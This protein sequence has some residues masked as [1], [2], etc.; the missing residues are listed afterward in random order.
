LV[1]D[2]EIGGFNDQIIPINDQMTRCPNDQMR[3]ID[4]GEGPALVLIPGIQGRWEYV[5]PAVEALASSF[6]VITFALCDE[7]SSDLEFDGSRGFDAYAEQ[8]RGALDRCG[9]DRA[10]V[11]GIS[12]GG[13]VALRFAATH[14]DRTACLVLASTPGPGWH[15]RRRHEIYA[16]LPYLLGPLFLAETPWR[17]RREMAAAFPGRAARLR[18]AGS[19][20]MTVMR[21]PLSLSRMAARARLI[22]SLDAAAE[23]ARISVP[24][25][26]VTGERA[27]DHVVSVDGST[28]YV[29][30]IRDARGVVLG[31]TGHL[32]SI[33]RPHEFAAIVRDFA[34]RCIRRAGLQVPDV[35]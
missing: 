28:S 4:R 26:V 22:G 11:C 34:D 35:A 25:L 5:G 10:V 6:R 13:L 18:F 12:F 16:R 3:I 21:A 33:T 27:L 24:T 8:V 7:P 14:A 9:I 15:L 29:P 32:G 23:S 17:L 19:Q 31:R 1:I 30:L 2:W 20:L